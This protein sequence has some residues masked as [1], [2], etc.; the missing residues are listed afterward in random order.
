MDR[1]REALAN[2]PGAHVGVMLDTKGPEIR[3]GF[4]LPEL[5]GKLKLVKN[6]LIE[7]GTDYDRL[8]NNEYLACS[9]KGIL[10]LSLLLCFFYILFIYKYNNINNINFFY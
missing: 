6:E 5:K 3:T 1:L 10:S 7:I 2:R 9:Y 8:G 4:F